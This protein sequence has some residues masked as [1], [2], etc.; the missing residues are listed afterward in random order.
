MNYLDYEKLENFEGRE[1]RQRKPYPWTNPQGILTD[2]GFQYLVSH[3]PDFSLFEKSFGYARRFGQKGHDKYALHYDRN[4]PIDPAWHAFVEELQA[5]PYRRF[6]RKLYGLRPMKLSFH[7]HWSESG[8]SV[9]PH[10]DSR[11]KIGSHIFYLN[12]DDDWKAEWG[13]QTLV[14]DDH[15]KLSWQS[16]PEFSE[17]EEPIVAD[18]IGNRSM[19]FKRT[20]HSWH[21]VKAIDCPDGYF[22]KVFIVAVERVRPIREIRR[23]LKSL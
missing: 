22:R 20:P 11:S 18:A 1:F 21:G 5:P 3:L 23:L 9:S 2:E 15:G 8:N 6:L 14:L 16:A 13:G 10:C 19:A 4:L 12:T 7:W 17:F